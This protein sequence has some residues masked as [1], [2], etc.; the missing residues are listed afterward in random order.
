MTL[1]DEDAARRAARSRMFRN[2][3]IAILLSALLLIAGTIELRQQRIRSWDRILIVGVYPVLASPAPAVRA[4]ASALTPADFAAINAF[5]EREAARHGR[6]VSPPLLEFRLGKPIDELPPALGD[7]PGPLDIARWSLALRAYSWRV[8]RAHDLPDADVEVFLLLHPAGSP[9]V[10]DASLAVSRLRIALVHAE[11][12]PR[13]SSWTQIALAHELLHTAGATDKYDARGAPLH[14]DGYAEPSL[15]PR[16]PQAWCEIMAGQVPLDDGQF[17]EPR[18]L[19][20]C[21][22]GART[23]AEVGWAR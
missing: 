19:D 9:R 8:R 16:H 15:A 11:A 3:R 6:A 22:A 18:G 17:R 14:P 13:A 7:D 21:L 10:L 4:H 20:E 1:T 5:F 23:A 2:V 12:D